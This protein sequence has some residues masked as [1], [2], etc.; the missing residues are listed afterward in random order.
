MQQQQ[1]SA[2]ALQVAIQEL[3]AMTDVYNKYARFIMFNFSFIISFSRSF[4][5]HE[6][7]HARF[8]R[9]PR[10]AAQCPPL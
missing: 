5:L 2:M 9:D 4:L 7:R 8:P 3:E 10:T 6:S 1:A